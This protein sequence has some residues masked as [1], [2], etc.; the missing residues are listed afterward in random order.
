MITQ[1]NVWLMSRIDITQ[2]A[3]CSWKVRFEHPILAD[4]REEHAIHQ[5]ILHL[6]DT[7]KACSFA[8]ITE[9]A[10]WCLGGA[11]PQSNMAAIWPRNRLKSSINGD[12]HTI[13]EKFAL[14][15][16]FS[17]SWA[18]ALLSLSKQAPLLDATSIKNHQDL[19]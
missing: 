19:S 15:R 4:Q 8:G 16:N 18:G 17:S 10:T 5:A 13:P 7:A 1:P 14:F 6:L 3:G 12:S 11:R 2:A 9:P